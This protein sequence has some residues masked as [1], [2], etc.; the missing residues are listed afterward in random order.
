[1]FLDMPESALGRKKKRKKKMKSRLFPWNSVFC[2]SFKYPQLHVMVR[3]DNLVGP[4]QPCDSMILY[5][6]MFLTSAAEMVFC[7]NTFLP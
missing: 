4:F 3:L 7:L 2:F 6:F 5:A 1:M